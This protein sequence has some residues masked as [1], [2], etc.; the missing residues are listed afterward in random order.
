MTD[1]GMVKRRDGARLALEPLAE[2]CVRGFD[3]D[4]AADPR[5]AGFV[6]LAHAARADQLF[7]FVGAQAGSRLELDGAGF[8]KQRLHRPI[9]NPLAIG[10]LDK[11]RPDLALQR[12]I[13]RARASQKGAALPGRTLERGLKQPVDLLPPFRI[14]RLCPGV[15]D[16]SVHGATMPLAVLQSRI[17][18]TAETLSTS[19]VSSTLSP[20]K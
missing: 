6:N 19:A 8:G 16:A 13:G 10:S 17:T 15:H 12:F 14:H 7:D 9:E 20:P 3:R 4:A 2:P 18:V 11:Q 5:V 1:V